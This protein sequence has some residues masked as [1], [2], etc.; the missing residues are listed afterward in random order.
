MESRRCFNFLPTSIVYWYSFANGLD[1]YQ[2]RQDAGPDLDPSY[3]DIP[4]RILRK[5]RFF[6]KKKITRRQKRK[7]ITQ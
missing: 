2:A 3:Y 1:P 6:W 4:E 5:I 7:K